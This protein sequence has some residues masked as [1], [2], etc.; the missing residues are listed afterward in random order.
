MSTDLPDSKEEV[1][2][3]TCGDVFVTYK[4]WD[5]SYCSQECQHASMDGE[6][7]GDQYQDLNDISGENHPRWVGREERECSECREEFV[8]RPESPRSTCSRECGHKRQAR[9][10]DGRE[11]TDREIRE[12]ELDECEEQFRVLPT[13]SK[14]YCSGGCAKSGMAGRKVTWADKISESMAEHLQD[15]NLTDWEFNEDL[16][17]TIRSSWE[18]KVARILQ[19]AGIEY[20]YEGMVLEADGFRYIP[21]FVCGEVVIE[22]KGMTTDKDKTKAEVFMEQRDEQY[23][24]VGGTQAVDIPCDVYVDIEEA[25]EVLSYV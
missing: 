22:V 19:D 5:R 9:L 17:H 15:N 18:E 13:N 12:C 10:M 11:L 21:D 4:C 24:V 14:K 1:T 6:W 16:G 8:V 20:S 3:M 25:E 7:A 23:A 2:C